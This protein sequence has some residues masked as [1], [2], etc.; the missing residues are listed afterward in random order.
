VFSSSCIRAVYSMLEGGGTAYMIGAVRH[1]CM[2]ASPSLVF[3]KM[4]EIAVHR[5]IGVC[6]HLRHTSHEQLQPYVLCYLEEALAFE[7]Y[8]CMIVRLCFLGSTGFSIDDYYVQLRHDL[9]YVCKAVTVS[10]S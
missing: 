8:V 5:C 6:T 4:L 2:S 9:K 3:S 10:I 7:F 1:S